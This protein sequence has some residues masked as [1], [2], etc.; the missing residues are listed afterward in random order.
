MRQFKLSGWA[1]LLLTLSTISLTSFAEVA[2]DPVQ[3]A[4]WVVDPNDP[5]DDLPPTGRSLFDLLFTTR[6]GNEQV[7]DIP[8]PFSRVIERI[9]RELPKHQS[10]VST[11]KKVLIPLGRSLQRDAAAPDFFKYPRV[12]LAVDTEPTVPDGRRPIF[13]KDRLFLGYQEKSNII[14]VISYNQSAGRFEFQVVK[15]YGPGRRPRVRYANRALCTSCHQNGAPIFPQARW[16]ET[17]SNRLIAARLLKEKPVFYGIVA[18]PEYALP[19]AMDSATD[20]ANLFSAYQLLWREGCGGSQSRAEAIRCRAGAFTAMLQHRLGAFSH[21]DKHARFYRDYF[22][23]VLTDN[24]WERWPGGLYIPDPNIANRVPRLASP[25]VPAE[26][27]PLT[28][29]L[30]LTTWSVDRDLH[31]VIVGLSQF[32]PAAD[33]RR[34]DAYLFDKG[35]RTNAP[36]QRFHGVCEFVRP[37]ALAAGNSLSVECG[38]SGG[39]D[40]KAFDLVADVLIESDRVASQTVNALAMTDGTLLTGLVHSRGRIKPDG[41]HWAANLA[42][43]ERSSGL[44]VR[45]PDGSV[46]R[47]V[48]LRWP[49]TSTADGQLPPED[50]FTGEATLTVMHDFSPVNDAIADMIAQVDENRLDVFAAKP[51]RGTKAM[52]VLFSYLGLRPTKWCC[53]EVA[54]M[55]RVRV[56][57][58]GGAV[59]SDLQV[60][61]QQHGALRTFYRYCATCHRTDNRFPPNFLSGDPGQV[62]INLTQCAERIL[63]RLHM[64]QLPPHTRPKSPMPPASRLRSLNY[65]ANEWRNSTELTRLQRYVKGLLENQEGKSRRGEDLLTSDYEALRACLNPYLRE[66]RVH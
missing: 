5:G 46:V 44:H 33:L 26:L 61:L 45:L 63:F 62:V 19:A 47:E 13:L 10:G 56:D 12:L 11:L 36:Q 9:E 51:F 15:D 48:Q 25:E 38:M 23:P 8:F 14:E 16:D 42:L 1:V 28:P 40:G 49:K 37:D 32:L 18:N 6:E 59:D 27:D 31:R 21:F 7:Y 57:E 22:V 50:R 43:S 4:T 29:R 3:S 58:G 35:V 55:P 66:V 20:R 65:S 30:P 39:S 17:N 60:S 52:Q 34:L 64:W 24:W 53:D 2:P 54:R 41:D